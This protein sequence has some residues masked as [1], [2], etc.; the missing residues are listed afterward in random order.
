MVALPLYIVMGVFMGKLIFIWETG[1]TPEEVL[2][3]KMQQL[4]AEV[5]SW[6]LKL[7]SM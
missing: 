4:K 7:L 3:N 5:V 1:T 2:Q 6:T